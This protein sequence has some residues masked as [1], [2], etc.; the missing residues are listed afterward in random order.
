M[1]P[2]DTAGRRRSSVTISWDMLDRLSDDSTAPFLSLRRRH[3]CRGCRLLSRRPHSQP[4]EQT[5]RRTEHRPWQSKREFA[6]PSFLPPSRRHRRCCWLPRTPSRPL[7]RESVVG[8]LSW[9]P[10]YCQPKEVVWLF[11]QWHRTRRASP[12]SSASRRHLLRQSAL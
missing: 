3:R 6:P 8:L 5:K 11:D 9:G 4:M 12:L 2:S 7:L 10:R 1:W